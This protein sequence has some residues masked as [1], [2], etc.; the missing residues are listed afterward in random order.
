[1]NRLRC[2][3]SLGCDKERESLRASLWLVSLG[4][5]SFNSSLSSVES[6]RIPPPS[7]SSFSE[8]SLYRL[9]FPFLYYFVSSRSLFLLS[10]FF[11]SCLGTAPR[12]PRLCVN[13]SL[14]HRYFP[15]A[16]RSPSSAFRSAPLLLQPPCLRRAA[17]GGLSGSLTPRL[18]PLAPPVSLSLSRPALAPRPALL[19][20]PPPPSVPPA[21]AS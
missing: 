14:Q 6:F 19:G 8:E 9:S 2:I 3:K 17:A 11:Y 12:H 16:A 20:L 7:R 5:L 1:M 10:C 18:G 4:G 15:A 13:S 21:C